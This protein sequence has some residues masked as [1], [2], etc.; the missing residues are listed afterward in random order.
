M[1]YTPIVQQTVLLNTN[2][3]RT[4][5]SLITTED[6]IIESDESLSVSLESDDNGVLLGPM[7][8]ILIVNDDEG[9]TF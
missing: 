1:D 6:E 5:V 9:M 4:C 8:E 7:A 3:N 2:V